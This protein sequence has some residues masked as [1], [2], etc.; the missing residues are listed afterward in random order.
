MQSNEEEESEADV[1][2]NFIEGKTLR[3]RIHLVIAKWKEHNFKCK[4]R[5]KFKRSCFQAAWSD[6][7]PCFP[8]SCHE[9]KSHSW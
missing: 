6:V 4:D 9:K 2:E 1:Q 8:V 7:V 3:G 5:G